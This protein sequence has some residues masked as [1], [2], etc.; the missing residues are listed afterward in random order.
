M[1][2]S[3]GERPPG[4]L[5]GS[6]PVLVPVLLPAVLMMGCAGVVPERGHDQV[7]ALVQK[8]TG[9]RTGW[10]K[11]PPGDARVAVWVAEAVATP[12]TR[13]KA[14]EIALV[15]NPSLAATY[16]ELGISQADM[17][18]AGKLRNPGLGVELGLPLTNGSLSEVRFS[19]VQDFLDLFVLPQR[20]EIARDQ[21]EADTLRVAHRALE[22][23][24]EVDKA[25]VA[26]QAA[27]SLVEYRRSLS[28]VAQAAAALSAKQLAAGNINALEEL[29]QRAAGEDATAQLAREEL[30][31][32]EARERMN[33][34]LGLWGTTTAWQLGEGLP[35]V[36]GDEP[37]LDHLE[38]LALRQR[39]DIASA[40]MQAAL[41]GK[42]VGLARTTRLVGHLEVGIDAH[43]DP[44]GPRVIGPNLVI[45]LPIFDQRQGYIARLE[46]LQRQQE[47]RLAGLSIDA[48]GE[49]R[50]AAARLRAA[51]LMVLRYRDTVVPLRKAILDEALL[52]Y[53]GMTVGAYQLLATKQSELESRRGLVEST[54]D[55]WV[56]RAELT[57]AL[58][59]AL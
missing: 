5:P 34:L 56:A 35:P 16:E 18:Q 1:F 48:R 12:L 28:E 21:F 51:R 45:E 47:R 27:T 25:F 41:L 42:A 6:F 22:V 59:G 14:I 55:Y 4:R 13:A 3:F 17:V 24:A 10:D 20:K 49:V 8:R 15:N 32:R 46:G 39:L 7:A 29:T 54:R 23:A 50:T 57:R 58:G 40:R 53:N 11:G 26:F 19:L 37:S 43:R 36:T 31:V 30:D 9:Y 52:H 33:Q 2:A 44:D 38:T